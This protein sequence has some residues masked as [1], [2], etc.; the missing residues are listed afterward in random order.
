MSDFINRR[1]SVDIR[2]EE[3]RRRG[4]RIDTCLPVVAELFAGVEYSKSRDSNHRRLTLALTRITAWPFDRA[5]A[6]EFG[7]IDAALRRLG[8]V[9][10]K[11]DTQIGA[12]ALSM[13]NTIVVSADGDLQIVPGL[14]VE[15]W[16]T[17]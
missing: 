1:R 7:R 10:G 12:I 11:V 17:A 2:V 6:E 9:I 13:G 3:V 15:N 14:K 16:A 5:A 4:D 8:R